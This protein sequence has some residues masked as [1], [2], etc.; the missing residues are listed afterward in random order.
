MCSPSFRLVQR[1]FSPPSYL[2]SKPYLLP[3]KLI[4]RPLWTTHHPGTLEARSSPSR[5]SFPG[6]LLPLPAHP[7]R[8]GRER[9]ARTSLPGPQ[10][11]IQSSITAPLCPDLICTLRVGLLVNFHI[12]NGD[13]NKISR[14]VGVDFFRGQVDYCVIWPINRPRPICIHCFAPLTFVN[15]K[16]S[17]KLA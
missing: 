12:A 15:N 14:P 6:R 9:K 11:E 2:T 17:E 4:T 7:G 10:K 3:Q 13:G 8:A 16:R 5:P 1:S